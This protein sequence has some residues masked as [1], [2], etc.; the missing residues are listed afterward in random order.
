MSYK[1]F[2]SFTIVLFFL[3]FSHG[4]SFAEETSIP[5]LPLK[6][7]FGTDLIE[8]GYIKIDEITEYSQERGFGWIKKPDC[9]RERKEANPLYHDFVFS[10]EPAAFRIDVK[11]GLYLITVSVVDI[12]YNDHE[13][14]LKIGNENFPIVK[15]DIAEL[16][17]LSATVLV[18][19]NFIII[20]FDS[21]SK[22]W[23]V[24]ALTLDKAQKKE[25]TKISKETLNSS[26]KIKDTWQNVFECNDPIKPFMEKFR[27]NLKQVKDFE[28]TGFLKDEY[29]NVISG[30][31]DFFKMF[32]DNNGAII[33]PY[34]KKE[35][36]YS[37]PCFALAAARLVVSRDRK[38]LLEPAMKALDWS[39]LTLS[40][41]KAA[42]AHE[43][44]FS[45]QI[46]HA[47]PLLKSFASS[48]RYSKWVSNMSSFDPIIT[49][50]AKPGGGNWNVVALSGEGL[51]NIMGIRKDKS[52][53]NKS[54][55]AQGTY[56]S[57]PWGLYIEGPMPYDHFPRIWAADMLAHGYNG[58]YTDKLKEV[59]R[60]GAITS[61]FMQSP[62]G[63]LPAGG[64]S[65]HHQWNE[66]EQC[67]TYELYAL[68]AKDSGDEELAGI[69]K[70]AAHLALLSIKRWI[71]PSG[72]LWIVKN[73][74][75]P[76]LKHG[77][78]GYSSHSQYN[79]LAMAML[80]IAYEYAERTDTI[81]EKPAPAD[82][83]GFVFDIGSPF[84]KIF[85]NAGGMYIEIDYL[86]DLHYNSTGLLRIHKSGFNPQLGPSDVLS[87]HFVSKYP[88][89][90]RTTA[91]LGVEWIDDKKKP[92][93]LAEFGRIKDKKS[94][95]LKHDLK[96]I[97]ESPDCVEFEIV[98]TGDLKGPKTVIEHYLV[99]KDYTDY[100]VELT[101]YKNK[102]R[103]II[104]VL[105]NNGEK[106]TIIE[107]K[108][109][110]VSVVLDNDI[111]NYRVLKA[112]EI[113]I[114]EEKYP[115]RNGWA[116]LAFAEYKKNK[117]I[118]LRIKPAKQ[119]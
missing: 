71:R 30:V 79:L 63:E 111:Q 23:I 77:Y 82:I 59:L 13:L 26:L 62:C 109:S 33:D 65:A 20:N 117:K 73:K 46:A 116:K 60:R 84:N 67:L 68:K 75:D 21:P 37:T 95:N 34:E 24:N 56:F 94:A 97:K 9:V 36:Q 61:L 51:L 44:F 17:V 105:A 15:P 85:A 45:P 47:I 54:L 32:Q 101:E 78:E 93:R 11:P 14:E 119:N 49:Y 39:T 66:A 118:S 58:D 7:D 87:E 115:F 81:K 57:S 104:P 5:A 29:L 72:E 106:D 86:A 40:Q 8:N 83:G 53:I 90:P 110:T 18:E 69:Y 108:N 1:S 50:R 114:S 112:N 99:T 80:S 48:E 27:N 76:S 28:S 92:V 2:M 64:R 88:K 70:R 96:I 91:A 4:F 10:R 100:S 43:D 35:Y 103:L 55:A 16:A 38:D 12:L 107:V 52:F 89:T 41:R 25:E 22:N 98:Y 19:N 102:A 31:V 42:S 74:M 6:F 113:K 3:I